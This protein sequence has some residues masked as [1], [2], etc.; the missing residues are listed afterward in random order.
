M[1]NVKENQRDE[2]D[3][4]EIITGFLKKNARK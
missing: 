3:V 4:L 1:I 2:K